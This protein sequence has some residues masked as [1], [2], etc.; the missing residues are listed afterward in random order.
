M[1]MPG[2]PKSSR[3]LG[4]R[5]WVMARAAGGQRPVAWQVFLGAGALIVVALVVSQLVRGASWGP[6]L[7]M[8]IPL[9]LILAI[10][11]LVRR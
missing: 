1:S 3:S 7:I 11:I 2:E 9:A 6:A 5:R 10:G 8:V 4:P